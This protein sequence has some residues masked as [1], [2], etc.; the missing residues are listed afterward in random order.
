MRKIA[1]IELGV[2]PDS[3]VFQ[4]GKIFQKFNDKNALTFDAAAE[5]AYD[6]SKLPDNMEPTLFEYTAFSPK[7]WTWPYGTHIAVVE[8]E[9]NTGV[10]KVLD[11]VAVDDIGLVINPMLAEGQVHGG[12]GQGAGQAL[13]EGIVYNQDGVLT[14]ASFLDYVIPQAGDMFPIRWFTTFTPTRANPLSVKGIGENGTVAATPAIVNAVE[15]ALSESG[16]KIKTMPLSP[17]YVL[18]FINGKATS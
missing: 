4:D 15:D 9:R 18:S 17:D 14:T 10:I 1:S 3:L 8:V 7:N 11:Y 6:P 12:V 13:L 16:A 2:E 5:L